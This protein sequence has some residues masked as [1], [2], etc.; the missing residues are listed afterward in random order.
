MLII[1]AIRNISQNQE[2]SFFTFFI[3]FNYY[4]SHK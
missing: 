4:I 1:T 2:L 3:L